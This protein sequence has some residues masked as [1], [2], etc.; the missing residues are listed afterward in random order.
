MAAVHSV[1]SGECRISGFF[2][3]FQISVNRR[4]DSISFLTSCSGDSA[5]LRKRRMVFH[6]QSLVGDGKQT[7]DTT[8]RCDQVQG[9]YCL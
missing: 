4:T 1:L 6:H 7:V 8:W 2:F 5:L 9:G 3:F